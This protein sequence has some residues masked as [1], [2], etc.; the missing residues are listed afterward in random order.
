[1]SKTVI[2]ISGSNLSIEEINQ[3]V[4]DPAIKI[5]VAE[6]ARCSVKESEDFLKRESTKRII[7]GVNTGFGPMASHL[8][9]ADRQAELQRNLVISHAM[10][11]GEPIEARFV[12]AAMVV[13]L[14][15]LV[16]GYAG[17]SLDLAD[18][19]EAFINHRIIP[20]VPEH[21]AVGTSGDLVQLAHIALAIIGEGK[22]LYDGKIQPAAQ[23]IKELSLGDYELKPKE[24]LALINGTAMMSGIA[25]LILAEAERAVDLATRFGAWAL[26]LVHGFGDSI[27]EELHALRPHPGQVA[28]AAHLRRTLQSSSLIRDRHKFRP[29][30]KFDEVVEKIPEDVQEVYSLRC[31]PQIVGPIWEAVVEARRVIMIEINS[32]TDNP[33]IAKQKEVFFHGGN[34]H[35]EYIASTVD[36]LKAAITK[37]T[38]L[39]ERRVN[40]FLNAKVNQHFPPFLNLHQPG[41]SLALQGLQFVATSIAADNQSLAFPHRLHSI[42]TNGDNQDV[43]SMGTDAALMAAKVVGNAYLVLAIEL[44]TLAQAT[45]VGGDVKSFSGETQRLYQ[46]VRGIFPVVSTDRVAVD[47]LAKVA[48]LVRV[49]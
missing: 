12:L 40:F 26:E 39:E 37:L 6:S 7:Y 24:G 22:V 45:D 10:G 30:Q 4:S 18:R 33:V 20:I 23:V 1:M 35:G 14:N 27:A 3:I 15:T 34:F 48:E 46:T 21:G 44:I 5:K 47:E 49:L 32:V 36:E 41:L 28:V 17:V 9:G 19:F 43:V 16:R 2:E 11:M 13:R 31:I 42:S 8:I 29:E 25:A 38:L